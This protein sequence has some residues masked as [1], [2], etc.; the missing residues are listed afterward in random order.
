MNDKLRQDLQDTI[1]RL[2]QRTALDRET[3]KAIRERLTRLAWRLKDVFDAHD[4]D[5][6]GKLLAHADALWKNAWHDALF[7]TILSTPELSIPEQPEPWE[8]D[9][10]DR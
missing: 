6:L 4:R 7:P 3:L 2:T 9:G 10:F 1:A 5:E 8:W